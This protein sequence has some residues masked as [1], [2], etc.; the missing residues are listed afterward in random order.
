MMD[1]TVPK[2]DLLLSLQQMSRVAESKSTMPML[3]AVHMDVRGDTLTMSA[4]D[5]YL[6]LTSTLKVERSTSG[7]V[8]VVAKDLVERVKA[9]PDGPLTL[10]VDDKYRI[11]LR[12]AGKARKFVV[13]GMPGDDFPPVARPDHQAATQRLPAGILAGLIDQTIDA[14]SS[15]DTRAH[16]ASLKIEWN[17][18]TLRAVATDGHRLH[19]AEAKTKTHGGLEMLVPR[20]GVAELRKACDLA[21]EFVVS[22]TATTAFFS[23]DGS[24][25][26]VK[27]T[28]A[29]FLP[30]EQVIPKAWKH[31]STV[32]VKALV[33][34]VR[35]V[36]VSCN[37]RTG[38]VVLRFSKGSLKV[39]SE[40][41]EGGEAADEVELDGWSSS[42]TLRVGVSHAYLVQVLMAAKVDAVALRT[43]GELDPILVY[44]GLFTGVAMPMRV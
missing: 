25:L 29:Q 37:T 33:E 22:R 1:L 4:T 5:L 9:M 21:A 34:A 13:A 2:R 3:T 32:D 17:G 35:A 41:P 26:S 28:D 7:S 11:T 39:E 36:A 43:T 44:A 10:V 23:A 31:E 8:A 20:K 38:C 16:L 40:S 18:D 30:Y 42:E 19:K 24:C 12:A 27:L 6:G 15:D 14:V